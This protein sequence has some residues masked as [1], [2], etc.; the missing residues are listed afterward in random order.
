M[1]ALIRKYS[2]LIG[3]VIAILAALYPKEFASFGEFVA[4]YWVAFWLPVLLVVIVV[5]LIFIIFILLKR[6]QGDHV[7]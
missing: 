5:L 4:N 1:N 7:S 2:A 6:Q 3:T